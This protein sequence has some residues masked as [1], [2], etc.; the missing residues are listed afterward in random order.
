M[1]RARG[2]GM[3]I[4]ATPGCTGPWHRTPHMCPARHSLRRSLLWPA[5]T[6][7]G[8][9]ARRWWA[10]SSLRD[11]DGEAPSAAGAY[12]SSVPSSERMIRGA[13]GSGWRVCACT[14]LRCALVCCICAENRPESA[15]VDMSAIVMSVVHICQNRSNLCWRFVFAFLKSMCA[16]RCARGAA[17]DS[18]QIDQ[19]RSGFFPISFVV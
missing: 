1:R 8:C 13:F 17:G 3:A 6:S 2:S 15:S 4:E 5:A 10:G 11:N 19:D 9:S 12:F 7:F 16:L 18:L 14:Y